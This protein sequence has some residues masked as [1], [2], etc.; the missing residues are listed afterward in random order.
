MPHPLLTMRLLQW[1]VSMKELRPLERVRLQMMAETVVEE[2]REATRNAVSVDTTGVCSRVS[3]C[4]VC[5][6]GVLK[7]RQDAPESVN[8]RCRVSTF[9]ASFGIGAEM[10]FAAYDVI[11]DNHETSSMIETIR[12]VGVRHVMLLGDHGLSRR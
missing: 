10:T 6:D 1:P 8:D 3:E 5:H 4:L 9:A 2:Q 12:R 7:E 11:V